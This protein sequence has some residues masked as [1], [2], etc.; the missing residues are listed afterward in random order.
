MRLHR[1]CFLILPLLT[2]PAFADSVLGT[3]DSF[4]VLGASAV[5]NTGNTTII[6]DLGVSPGYSYTGAGTVTQTGSVYISDGVAALAQANAT[7]AYNTLAAQVVTENLTG[8]DLGGMTLTPGVYKF[9]SSAQLTGTLTLDALGNNNATWVFLIGS[10][11]TTATDA[12]VVFTDLGSTPDDGLYWQVG[13]SA[14]LGTGTAFEGNI[15]AYANV[16]MNTGATD[17]CG[18]ALALTGS[19][20][21][22]MNTV[23]TGC[24]GL[25]PGTDVTL[26]GSSGLD[27]GL[28]GSEETPP[29]PEPGS[30]ALL[31]SG[32]IALARFVRRRRYS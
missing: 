30:M 12:N 5:T 2:L 25:A 24:S 29:V 1:L 6:G 3:A 9:N 28:G 27:G 21:M 14:T 17:D 22:D 32:L 11:L 15:L 26:A 4:A 10:T 18:R 7:T 13:S 23:S 20:T 16:G 19:V 8:Q 31:G